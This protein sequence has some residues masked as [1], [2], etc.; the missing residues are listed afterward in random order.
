ME[1]STIENLAPKTRASNTLTDILILVEDADMGTISPDEAKLAFTKMLNKVDGIYE[2]E[3]RLESRLQ[4]LTD[5]LKETQ[6]AKKVVENKLAS[7]KG[8]IKYSMELTSQDRIE[9]SKYFYS[10]SKSSTADV[11]VFSDDTEDNEDIMGEFMDT[12]MIAVSLKWDKKK[13]RDVLLAAD[14]SADCLADIC[15]LES[16]TKSRALKRGVITK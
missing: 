14:E 13:M 10:L 3:K 7:I 9:G 4:F 1:T 8:Y 16:K 12:D 5:S 15:H 6:A 2:V 11:M